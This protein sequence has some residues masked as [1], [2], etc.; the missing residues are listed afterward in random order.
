M[1][2]I[3][4]YKTDW[5]FTMLSKRVKTWTGALPNLIADYAIIPEYFNEVVRSGSMLRWAE[6]L[7][8]DTTERRAMLEGYALVQQRLHTD[9]PP[10]ETGAAILLDV[11]KTK[12]SRSA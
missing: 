1:P 2:T 9:V 7:S 8:S 3:S 11:L 4:V 12:N 6:R 10:G 5:I